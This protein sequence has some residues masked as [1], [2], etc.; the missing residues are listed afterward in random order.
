MPSTCWCNC[1][2]LGEARVEAPL[3]AALLRRNPGLSSPGAYTKCEHNQD[4]NNCLCKVLVML[5]FHRSSVLFRYLSQFRKPKTCWHQRQELKRRSVLK[6]QLWKIW[7]R[8][9]L[10][11]KN[12][13]VSYNMGI[14]IPA[15]LSQGVIL[16]GTAAKWLQ[17]KKWALSAHPMTK[18]GFFLHGQFGPPCAH[19]GL[20]R[21]ARRLGCTKCWSSVPHN[22]GCSACAICFPSSSRALQL[23]SLSLERSKISGSGC[24]EYA[25]A[26]V[27]GH[28]YAYKP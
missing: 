14:Y 23:A 12:I 13:W 4:L 19:D 5:L 18:F 15:C 25:C 21:T 26:P 11:K 27:A 20:C 16:L 1:L 3:L 8:I 17:G 9:V 22:Y 10:T 6:V 7:P 28:L 24:K 2:S